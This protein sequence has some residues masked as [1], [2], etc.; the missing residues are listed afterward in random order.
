[1]NMTVSFSIDAFASGANNHKK[2]TYSPESNYVA[3]V[4]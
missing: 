2:A 1:M 3:F 4:S